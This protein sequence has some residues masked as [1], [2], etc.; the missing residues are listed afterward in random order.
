MKIEQVQKLSNEKLRIKVAELDGWEGR[1]VTVSGSKKP[2][3]LWFNSK[4]NAANR[5]SPPDYTHDLNAM[6]EAEKTITDVF[7]RRRY[8]QTLDQLTGDQWNTIVSTARQRTEAFVVVMS[9]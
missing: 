2:I 7:V 1:L 4:R 5:E 9:E 8:Y 6:H 3:L